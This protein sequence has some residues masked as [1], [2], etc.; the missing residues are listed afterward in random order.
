[1]CKQL[2]LLT[3]IL[4]VIVNVYAGD[5]YACTLQGITSTT[6]ECVSVTDACLADGKNNSNCIRLYANIPSRDAFIARY[7]VDVYPDFSARMQY[8][9]GYIT[10]RIIT[11]FTLKGAA[12]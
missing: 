12:K 2:K 7:G 6:V 1:M 3:L 4:P 10:D 8:T 11:T 9:P 5:I